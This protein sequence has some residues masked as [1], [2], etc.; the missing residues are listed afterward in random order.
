MTLELLKMNDINQRIK[1][2][3]LLFPTIEYMADSVAG[4]WFIRYI[5]MHFKIIFWLAKVLNYI[6]FAVQAFFIG[7]Y[8]WI[9]S[10]PLAL[11]NTAYIHFKPNVLSKIIYLASDEMVHVQAPAYDII[12]QNKQRLS[13]VYSITDQWA[14]VT[15]YERLVARFPAIDATITDEFTHAFVLSASPDVAA[16]IAGRIL[17]KMKT[18]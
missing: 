17:E 3:Y 15:Y 4:K 14:P 2:S 7:A 12:E 10:I 16:F 9:K 18:D 1:H 6:P 11:L 8:F 13:F 5:E